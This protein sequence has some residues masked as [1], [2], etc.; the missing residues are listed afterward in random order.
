MFDVLDERIKDNQEILKDVPPN[1]RKELMKYIWEFLVLMSKQ[2]PSL[3][4][5]TLYQR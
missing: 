1:E 5:W 4:E 3:T 2:E